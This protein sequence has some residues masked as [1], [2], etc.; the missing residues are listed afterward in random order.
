MKDTPKYKRLFKCMFIFLIR[1]QIL[2]EQVLLSFNSAI[3]NQMDKGEVVS[4]IVVST[5][6]EV[7]TKARLLSWRRQYG[8]LLSLHQILFLQ[9]EIHDLRGSVHTI[10]L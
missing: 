10:S 4:V 7:V 1:K 5:T 8:V 2:R 6:W 9:H 3:E